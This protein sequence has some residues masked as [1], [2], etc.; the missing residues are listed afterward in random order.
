MTFLLYELAINPDIQ[1]KLVEE[2]RETKRKSNGF[3]YNN[4]Q[5]MKY[6]DMVVSG[7]NFTYIIS[8]LL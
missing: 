3:D 7:K 5:Y 6:L 8:K 2:I 1:D 4:I